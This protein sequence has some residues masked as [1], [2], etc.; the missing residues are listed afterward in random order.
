M[1]PLQTRQDA[2]RRGHRHYLGRPCKTC[3][4]RK[5]YVVNSAC[6]ACSI[7]KARAQRIKLREALSGKGAP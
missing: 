5:R 4:S 3:G 2:I 6:C 1:E 7:A